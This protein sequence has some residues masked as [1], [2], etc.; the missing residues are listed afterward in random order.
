MRYRKDA[1][2][3]GKRAPAHDALADGDSDDVL[4]SEQLTST[5][6]RDLPAPQKFLREMSELES[7][8]ELLSA[9]TE[10]EAS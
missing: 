6:R 1:Q 2:H 4:S 8:S 9:I 5:C 3:T 7:R 10:Q